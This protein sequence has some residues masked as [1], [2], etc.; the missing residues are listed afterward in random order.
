MKFQ[1]LLFFLLSG[2]G[3]SAQTYY[4]F[5][6]KNTMW[7]EM[8][9]NPYP[10]EFSKFHSFM[11]KDNDTVINGKIYH[12]LYHST[13]TLFTEKNLCGAIREVNKKVYYYSFVSLTFPNPDT[14]SYLSIEP[15]KEVMLYDFSLELGDTLKSDSVRLVLNS[16]LIVEKIDTILIGSE[17]RK[18]YTFAH[19]SF[20]PH[21]IIPWA[22]WV[23][24]IGY[25]RGLLFRTGDVPSN[26][27]WNDIICFKEN[28]SWLY[29]FSRK[30]NKCFYMTGDATPVIQENKKIL[31][32]PNPIHSLAHIEFGDDKYTKLTIMDLLGTV[33]KV[34]KIK[35]LSSIDIS[36]S[37]LPNG[38]YILRLHEENGNIV[39]TKI[40]FE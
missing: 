6:T 24:G 37:E 17:Y 7:T 3:L 9:F 14:Y 20:S 40:V 22:Q 10:N 11:L 19:P 18:M 28:N 13:D 38:L 2:F 21:L 23:E 26:G 32:Y 25:L 29:H 16:N 12:K 36:K 27:L 30:Y 35:G 31:V 33:L 8:F 34:Y 5:P 4:P 15:N 1:I 39:S